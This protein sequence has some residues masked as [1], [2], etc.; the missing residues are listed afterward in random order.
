MDRNSLLYSFCANNVNNNCLTGIPP[1]CQMTLT[2]QEPIQH[3]RRWWRARLAMELFLSCRA[4]RERM[5]RDRSIQLLR[6]RR[7]FC[8]DGAEPQAGVTFGKA[9]NLY[10]TTELGGSN[11]VHGNRG[12]VQTFAGRKRDG[13]E[14]VLHSFEVGKRWW[15]PLGGVS[16]DTCRNLYGTVSG[17]GPDFCR[18]GFRSE[19]PRRMRKLNRFS[20]SM[21]LSEGNK[22]LRGYLLDSKATLY[23]TTTHR[24][25]KCRSWN[26]FSR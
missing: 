19:Y 21:V 10:G 6:H 3:N 26:G 16:L 13:R 11:N 12:C 1:S 23:G 20:S 22:P 14:T 18:R 5:D 15:I 9:R 7:I 2:R 8:L 24:W 4:G 25:S 17:G